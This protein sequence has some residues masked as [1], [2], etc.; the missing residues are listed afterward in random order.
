MVSS[1]SREY[2]SKPD[3][4]CYVCGCYILLRQRRNI[5]SFVKCAY[6]AYFQFPLVTKTRNGHLILCVITVR[7]CFAI[8]QKENERDCLLEFLWFGGNPEIM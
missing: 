6:K 1:R 3:S 4:F 5:T 7:K 2:K 8:G